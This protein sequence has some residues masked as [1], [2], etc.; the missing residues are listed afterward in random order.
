MYA[1]VACQSELS[2]LVIVAQ[3][4]TNRLER[5]CDLIAHVV[6]DHH[7]IEAGQLG[8]SCL[9]LGVPDGGRRVP[10]RQCV[11][12]LINGQVV[13]HDVLNRHF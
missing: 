8:D 3:H 13:A 11:A 9:A 10:E 2:V 4:V 6:S 7:L 1:A 12:H 5:D